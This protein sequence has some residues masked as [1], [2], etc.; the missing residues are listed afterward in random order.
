MINNAVRPRAD[1]DQ[2]NQN[3]FESKRLSRSLTRRI[4]ENKTVTRGCRMDDMP[5]F[6]PSVS[7]NGSNRPELTELLRS[8]SISSLYDNNNATVG[9]V[10]GTPLR[11]NGVGSIMAP[12]TTPARVRNISSCTT[13]SDYSASPTMSDCTILPSNDLPSVKTRNSDVPANV[14]SMSGSAM[15]SASLNG[16]NSCVPVPVRST[17]SKI[18][19]PALDKL[20]STTNSSFEP[21]STGGIHQ[22]SNGSYSFRSG[23][24]SYNSHNSKLAA[25]STTMIADNSALNNCATSV[26]TSNGGMSS[27]GNTLKSSKSSSSGNNSYTSN[28]INTLSTSIPLNNTI[29]APPQRFMQ[30]SVSNSPQSINIEQFNDMLLQERLHEAKALNR[31]SES[32]A[33][34]HRFSLWNKVVVPKEDS[35]DNN[36]NSNAS[37]C[38]PS[39]ASEENMVIKSSIVDNNSKDDGL[40]AHASTI[41]SSLMNQSL[42]L[43]HI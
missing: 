5:N 43:I 18:S 28:N 7:T 13:N 1:S 19:M 27:K 36:N 12:L 14:Q 21:I 42:S 22:K 20:S 2:N 35:S 31:K 23:N 9:S 34:M 37:N 11:S 8:S 40:I 10:V 15:T 6:S 25:I 39:T 38:H 3:N 24:N 33:I 26:T 41:S 32:G 16:L 17:L 4:K 29:A 30:E